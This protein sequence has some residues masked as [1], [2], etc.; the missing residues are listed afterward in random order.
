MERTPRTTHV[1]RIQVSVTDREEMVVARLQ[2]LAPHLDGE[3]DPA[4]RAATRARLV[5]MAAVRSPEPQPVSP[6]RRLL[7]AGPVVPARWRRRFTAGLAGAALTVTALA[8][9][10]ALSA[11]ARPGDALYALKRGT[12]QAQLALA[13]NSRGN[14]L[15]DLARTRLE[16]VRTLDGD[17]ALMVATLETMDA[18]TTEGA[19]WL[20]ERAVATRDETRL[21]TLDEWTEV[22]SASLTAMQADVPPS[23]QD[24]VAD[25]LVLLAEI[26]SRADGLRAALDCAAGPATT[27]FDELGPVPGLCLPEH[28]DPSTGGG[29]AGE[30]PATDP[31]TDPG[32]GPGPGPSGTGVPPAP[33]LTDPLLPSDGDGDPG[34]PDTGG[35]DGDVFDPL[36]PPSPP[37]V[38]TAPLP[39]TSTTEPGSDEDATSDPALDVD[40]CLPPLATLGDC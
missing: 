40:I 16:E 28:A 27:G 34:L 2:A 22:Q 17:A 38:G 25:S 11:D 9:V 21:E 7:T 6:I 32:P 19:A 39:G 36:L 12:E 5:A 10:V 13:G 15:L 26:S 1:R 31:G 33:G 18:Q 4:F 23:A 24:E 20:T 8:T 30:G 3:P 14:V 35:S 37:L 29:A